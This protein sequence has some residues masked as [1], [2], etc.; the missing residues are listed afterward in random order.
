MRKI[1]LAILVILSATGTFAQTRSVEVERQR[2][3]FLSH[4]YLRHAQY[5]EGKD[6]DVIAA[7]GW[8]VLQFPLDSGKYI[9][10][11]PKDPKYRFANGAVALDV[12]DDGN[13]ELIVARHLSI[14]PEDTEDGG[15]T[16]FQI[17]WYERVPG[18]ALWVL[19]EIGTVP[20]LGTDMHDMVKFQDPKS[21]VQ[22]VIVSSGRSALY[23]FEKP[24][25][26]KQPWK[27]YDIAKLPDPPQSG[28]SVGDINGD[29]RPDIVTG[30][31][32]LECPPDPRT[33]EWKAHR[34]GDWDKQ[35]KP[36]GSMNKH[37]VADF[38]GD[39]QLEIVADEAENEGSRVGIF[40][41]DPNNP[42]GL[43]KW[44]L[45]DT[46]LYCPHTLDVADLN[47]DGRPDFVIGEMDAGGWQFPYTPKPR[48]IAYLNQGGGKFQRVVLAEGLGTH[49]GKFA[50]K[51]F[52]GRL[53]FY[54]NN[55]IQGWFDGMVTNL[56]TWTIQPAGPPVEQVIFQDNFDGKLGDGWKWVR[57]QADAW[58]ASSNG[59]TMR[60]LTGT[61]WGETNTA[62]NLLLRPVPVDGDFATEVTVSIH[63]AL[64]SEQAGLIL[65][66]GDG[67]YIKLVDEFKGPQ[68]FLILAREEKDNAKEIGRI[69]APDGRITLRLVSHR[70]WIRAQARAEGAGGWQT[71]AECPALTTGQ[72]QVGVFTHIFPGQTDRS[73]QFQNFRLLN[74]SAIPK[75]QETGTARISPANP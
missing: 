7:W 64:D 34:Y 41:R 16:E 21:G 67:D 42:D 35:I 18:Q 46:G 71:V 11:V 24:K 75:P 27:R 6:G 26:P 45:I 53:L 22:G 74:E 66:G 56:T 49:E 14:G 72:L 19:H 20:A 50:P 37:G 8:R 28:M 47:G 43:W 73:A 54:A 62:R 40:K 38:D 68:P 12:N 52:Q 69:P 30:M 15:F 2:V 17:V 51:L 25:D 33:G 48:L 60:T 57:E 32:W 13:Q 59:L 39:G 10:V 61:L 58:K 1:F 3:L 29:G 63:S 44:S 5:L 65:Y 55:T 4:E 70:G 31:Y 36:W 9:E 23:L